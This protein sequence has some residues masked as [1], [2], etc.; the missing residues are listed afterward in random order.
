MEEGGD[1]AETKICAEVRAWVLKV[2][3]GLGLCPRAVKSQRKGLFRI[4]TCESELSSDVADMLETEI[5]LILRDGTPPLSTA[6]LV[7][8]YVDG[9]SEFQS[10]DDFVRF[11]I[12]NHFKRVDKG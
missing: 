11:G 8:P 3:I 1:P 4:V 12:R 5:E 10:F 7:C 9:W 2:P 6:L